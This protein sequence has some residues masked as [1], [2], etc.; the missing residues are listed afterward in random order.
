MLKKFN[1]Y[2]SKLIDFYVIACIL[3]KKKLRE[4]FATKYTWKFCK[5]TTKKQKCE[6]KL[7][8]CDLFVIKIK[9]ISSSACYYM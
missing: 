2:L 1:I 9:K 8:I 3:I 6:L 7:I 4:D 5:E